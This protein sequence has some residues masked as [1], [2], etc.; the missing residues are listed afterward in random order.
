MRLASFLALLGG[1]VVALGSVPTQAQTQS[2]AQPLTTITLGYSNVSG[3]IGMFVARAQGM[4]AKRGLQVDP[5]LVAINSTMPAALVGGSL[6]IA[7]PSPPVFLQAVAGGLDIAIIAGCAAN[8]TTQSGQGVV[9]RT[10]EHITVARDFDGKRVGVPGIG[11]Y[12]DVLFRRWLQ[13]NGADIKRISFVEVPFAQGGDVLRAGNVDAVLTSDPYYSRIIQSK[14]GYL[15]SHYLTQM[16]N[17]LG[18]LYYAANRQWAL[19]HPQ[20]VAAFR[21][22]IREGDAFALREPVKARQILAQAMKLPPAAMASIVIP[23]LQVD[24]TASDLQYW[25]DTLLAQ[26]IIRSRL[27]PNKLIIH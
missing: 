5:V 8:D 19:D 24:V 22:A 16:P 15:V 27:D 7:S 1:C 6:Q 25:I 4:F 14:A 11:A 2:H 12:M 3:F 18:S 20:L 23:K 10:G 26:G 17:G 9:A 21:D 13:S